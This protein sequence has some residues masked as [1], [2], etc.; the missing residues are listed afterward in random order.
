MNNY[1]GND[2]CP[3]IS[4]GNIHR[5]TAKRDT[6]VHRGDGGERRDINEHAFPPAASSRGGWLAGSLRF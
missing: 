1:K 4:G 3:S 6:S 5:P 2:S